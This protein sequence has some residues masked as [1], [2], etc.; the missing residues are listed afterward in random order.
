MQSVRVQ[1]DP[2]GQHPWR[3]IEETFEDVDGLEQLTSRLT[4]ND[5]GTVQQENFLAGVLRH[6]ILVNDPDAPIGDRHKPWAQIESRFNEKGAKIQTT[7]FYKNGEIRDRL[8]HSAVPEDKLEKYDPRL[9]IGIKPQPW[10]TVVISFDDQGQIRQRDYVFV[11]GS[12]RSEQYEDNF[13]KEILQEE[14]TQKSGQ[15]KGAEWASV[16]T[17]IGPNKVVAKRLTVLGNGEEIEEEYRDGKKHVRKIPAPD[18]EPINPA[19]AEAAAPEPIPLVPSTPSSTEGAISDQSG[20]RNVADFRAAA[21]APN[22][23]LASEGETPDEPEDVDAF[24]FSA[25]A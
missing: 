14:S 8:Q 6:H 9:L 11:D 13:I 19:P 16:V 24:V 7:T 1:E 12:S 22:S 15:G 20:N 21:Q 5:N 25:R 10:E 3:R 18:R 23:G 17:I 4:Y 2:T